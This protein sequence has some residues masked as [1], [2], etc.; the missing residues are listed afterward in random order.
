MKFTTFT[1]VLAAIA[2]ALAAQ[3]NAVPGKDASLF[4]T[5]GLNQAGRMGTYPNGRN[6]LS[7]GVR[8][9][10]SGNVNIDWRAPMNPLHPFYSF[11]VCRESGGRFVQI[12]DR[13]YVKHGFLSINGN[14]CGT[15][16]ETR[17]T[18]LGPNCS[19]TYSS[20]LNADRFYLGPPDEIDP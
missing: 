17:G 13:S 16:R 19:D 4:V 3:P 10:N 1:L 5:D 11:I 9:C 12:S 14:G 20:G 6:G 2:P 15:C 8:I 7:I 18:I